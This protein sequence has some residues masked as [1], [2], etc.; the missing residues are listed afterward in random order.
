M[1]HDTITLSLLIIP[2]LI[3]LYVN[4][5]GSGTVSTFQLGDMLSQKELVL[6]T[7]KSSILDGG[8]ISLDLFLRTQRALPA[9]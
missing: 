4:K 2:I 8:S 1:I 7:M 6:S 5:S 9:G 3:M